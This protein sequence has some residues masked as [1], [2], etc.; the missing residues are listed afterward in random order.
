MWSLW[1]PKITVVWDITLCNLVEYCQHLGGTWRL[2][3]QVIKWRQNIPGTCLYDIKSKYSWSPLW[4]YQISVNYFFLWNLY[5]I[6]SY[7]MR[8]F[9]LPITLPSAWYES[10]CRHTSD[11]V[12][13]SLR[14]DDN[15]VNMAT[16]WI[17]FPIEPWETTETCHPLSVHL[18]VYSI[19]W[20]SKVG[21]LEL[22]FLLNYL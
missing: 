6:V 21:C 20:D 15:W 18:T 2:L 3:F 10:T 4:A 7:Q 19:R 8:V 12:S 14:I 9:T 16:G 1:T 13:I 11:T 22:R 5:F 17:R